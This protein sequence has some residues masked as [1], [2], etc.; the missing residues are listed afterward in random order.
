MPDYESLPLESDD[1]DQVPNE[2]TLSVAINT[3]VVDPSVT[4]ISDIQL[5][6]ACYYVHRTFGLWHP[7]KSSVIF[8]VH[9]AASCFIL[10]G[11]CF[12]ILYLDR[13]RLNGIEI[14]NS[15]MT[16]ADF[17]TPF[18]FSVYYFRKGQ[19]DELI[20]NIIQQED[21][22]KQLKF[23]SRIFSLISV[24]LWLLCFLYFVFCWVPLNS[25]L[26]HVVMY[27]L[28]ALYVSGI[29]AAWL[30]LYG[31]VCAAHC[32]QIWR[33][34]EETKMGFQNSDRLENDKRSRVD[35]VFQRYTE[36]ENSLE[37][38][39][40][41]LDTIISTAVAIHVLDIIIFT[42]TFWNRHFHEHRGVTSAPAWLYFGTLI[43]DLIS[44]FIKLYSAG[45]IANV[46]H[47]ATDS[48]GKQCIQSSELDRVYNYVWK[49]RHNLSLHIL[50]IQISMNIAL[51]VIFTVVTAT[52]PLC[53]QLFLT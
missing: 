3:E 14:A 46:A 21:D 34:A 37:K 19:F 32:I 27:V 50:G 28:T 41:D 36:L 2:S 38:T 22:K 13:Y 11:C 44:V 49:R 24:V 40:K 51:A 26:C 4:E 8:K 25:N 33:F 17:L 29:W 31:Y 53:L 16:V 35:T 20:Q 12:A 10:L 42:C 47:K 45:K 43:F 1:L 52:I 9:Q 18:I 39:Q 23:W 6:R 30:S 15:I 7:R 5:P 48:I